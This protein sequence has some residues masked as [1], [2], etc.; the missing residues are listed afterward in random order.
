VSKA[1]CTD[2]GMDLARL[3]TQ[4]HGGMGYIEETGIAQR[5]R[6]IRIAAIYEGTNGIQAADLVGRKLPMRGGAVVQDFLA[7]M[8][9]VDGELEAAGDGLAGIRARLA[10]GLAILRRATTWVMANGAA[11]PNDALAAATPYLRLFGIVTGG[12]VMARQALAAHGAGADDPFLAAKVATAR[13]YCEEL[14][15]QAGGL[16]AAV[17]GGGAA[18][19]AVPVEQ[20]TH[21]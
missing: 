4:V 2:V 6:D 5:E 12:W 16:V 11:D 18:L 8:A 20:L 15:P 13:F 1:W 3:A 14:L 21:V 10:E 7:R 17:E 19:F 9:A